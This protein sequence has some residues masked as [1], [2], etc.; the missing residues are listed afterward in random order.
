MTQSKGD[1]I[2]P[3]LSV[4]AT[5][6][7]D[8]GDFGYPTTTQLDLTE[9][10]KENNMSGLWQLEAIYSDDNPTPTE[11]KPISSKDIRFLIRPEEYS[12]VEDEIYQIID[13]SI[14]NNNQAKAIK[15]LISK[16]FNQ[17]QTQLWDQLT[18]K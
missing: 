17:K 1:T 11:P 10:A 12:A 9:W 16:A 8:A 15:A 3:K 14:V 2:S 4:T 7:K 18:K 5:I 13:A 6:I